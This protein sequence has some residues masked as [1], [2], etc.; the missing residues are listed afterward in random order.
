M[1]RRKMALKVSV[2]ARKVKSFSSPNPTFGARSEEGGLCFSSRWAYILDYLSWSISTPSLKWEQCAGW[3]YDRCHRSF[4][5]HLLL[6]LP[7]AWTALTFTFQELLSIEIVNVCPT[8]SLL[9]SSTYF[10]LHSSLITGRSCHWNSQQLHRRTFLPSPSQHRVLRLYQLSPWGR[11]HSI[12]SRRWCRRWRCRCQSKETIDSSRSFRTF[13]KAFRM[14]F[15]LIIRSIRCK[16]GD[17]DWLLDQIIR[18]LRWFTLCLLGNQSFGLSRWW[19][20]RLSRYGCQIGS[21][22]R[23]HLWSKVGYC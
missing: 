23:F 13:P 19:L 18:R 7:W 20:N 1:E 6:Y 11:L 2:G 12:H 16:E 17:H 15:L 4:P 9:T 5:Y 14:D 3:C 10:S 22:C 8:I 21:N